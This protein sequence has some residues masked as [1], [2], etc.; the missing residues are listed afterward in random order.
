MGMVGTEAA[1]AFCQYIKEYER[2][3]TVEDVLKGK[4]NKEELNSLANSTI[5]AL[6]EN[7]GVHCKDNNWN[8]KQCK[9]IAAFARM[10]PGEQFVSVW[11]E[12]SRS[13]NIKNIQKMHKELGQE[14]VNAV[15][16][17]RE[18]GKK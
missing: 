17:S 15:R 8:M 9:A 14:V 11:N 13:N 18:L 10:L 12:I 5:Q 2:Q 6:I 7:V 3:V 1:I 16:A 4:L